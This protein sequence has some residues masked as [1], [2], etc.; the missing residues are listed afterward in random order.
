MVY[1]KRQILILLYNLIMIICKG[2]YIFLDDFPCS[3]PYR[4]EHI[5]AA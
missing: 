2:I 1:S 5:H 3:L 4:L